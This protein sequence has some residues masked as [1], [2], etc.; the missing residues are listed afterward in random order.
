MAH[1]AKAVPIVRCPK[2]SAGM[3]HASVVRVLPALHAQT[4]EIEPTWEETEPPPTRI[5]WV[6][7]SAT[8]PTGAGSREPR[9][10]QSSAFES[11][12]VPQPQ[13]MPW[14]RLNP[15][16][17]KGSPGR[18]GIM[19]PGTRTSIYIGHQEDFAKSAEFPSRISSRSP[20][21]VRGA[22]GEVASPLRA[23]FPGWEPA[24]V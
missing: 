8:S 15:T 5:R 19:D 6:R 18:R 2:Q 3:K 14:A 16:H 9:R 12:R 24:E 10:Q 4:G 22:P 7:Q 11:H 23:C 17:W 20:G 1:L 21:M 13:P